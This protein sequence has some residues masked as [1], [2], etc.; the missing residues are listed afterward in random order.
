MAI[1]TATAAEFLMKWVRFR[2]VHIDGASQGA[3]FFSPSRYSLKPKPQI[4][5][6]YHSYR[7]HG[8][9]CGGGGAVDNG[10]V[11]YLHLTDEELMRDCEMDTY[12]AS[13]PGGQHRNK[14]ESAVRIKHR[15]TGI[16]SQ[17]THYSVNPKQFFTYLEAELKWMVE[18]SKS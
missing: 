2:L 13:G 14:R 10:N 5:V 9:S 11:E 15:P 7:C 4:P 16:V 1:A 6:L 3:P 12:K 8:H 17:V 18:S